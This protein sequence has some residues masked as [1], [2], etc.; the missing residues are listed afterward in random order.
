MKVVLKSVEQFEPKLV[1]ATTH[2]THG[3]VKLKG[4]VKMSSRTGNFLKATE[5][6]DIA[7]EASRKIRAEYNESVTLGAVKY[8]FLKQRIGNDIVYDPVESVS[9]EGNSGPYLQYAYARSKSIL[10]KSTKNSQE[11]QDLQAG[12]R[13]LVSKISEY[14]EVID[15]AISDLMPSQVCNYLYELTQAF[16]SFY[17]HNRVL[18]DGRESERLWLVQIY[19]KTLKTG[20]DILGIVSPEKM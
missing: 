6:L 15:K 4:G 1:A 13:S 20:L 7:A 5:V 3:M 12:E 14:S 18:G 16:N 11:P 19:S 8:S 2:L 17:E 10:R 9:L